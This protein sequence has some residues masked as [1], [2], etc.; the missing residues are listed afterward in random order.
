MSAGTGMWTHD[1]ASYAVRAESVQYVMTD[2]QGGKFYIIFHMIH[3]KL[4]VGYE[5]KDDRDLALHRFLEFSR[6]T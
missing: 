6:T 3:D 5:N 2:E 1:G 4:T